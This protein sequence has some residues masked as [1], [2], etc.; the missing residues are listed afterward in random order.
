MI[1]TLCH[2]CPRAGP[3]SKWRAQ[4]DDFRTFL[5]EFVS[6]VPQA[7]FPL[8]DSRSGNRELPQNGMGRH[9]VYAEASVYLNQTLLRPLRCPNC[10]CKIKQISSRKSPIFCE[11]AVI[12]NG[13]QRRYLRRGAAYAD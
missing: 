13:D 6:S 7:E 9:R 1:G 10:S 5:N 2:V 3:R 12:S 11:I 4:G 8:I